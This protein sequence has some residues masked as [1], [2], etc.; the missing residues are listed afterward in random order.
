MHVNRLVLGSGGFP[1][2]RR[3]VVSVLLC[4]GSRVD[5]VGNPRLF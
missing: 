1:D 5:T 3:G 2:L 4:T